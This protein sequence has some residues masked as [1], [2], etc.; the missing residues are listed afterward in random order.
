MAEHNKADLDDSV[1][2]IPKNVDGDNHQIDKGRLAEQGKV[3]G[4]QANE[5]KSDNTQDLSYVNMKVDLSNS[6]M[7]DDPHNQSNMALNL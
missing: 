3:I 6:F 4:Q 5:Y 7:L 1:I 2:N